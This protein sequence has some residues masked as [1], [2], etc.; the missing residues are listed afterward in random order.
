MSTTLTVLILHDVESVYFFYSNPILYTVIVLCF[1]ST[2]S[3]PVCCASETCNYRV[4]HFKKIFS[5]PV[6]V[7]KKHVYYPVARFP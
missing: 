4:M 6:A 5:R 2:F 3:Y 1:T 7:F